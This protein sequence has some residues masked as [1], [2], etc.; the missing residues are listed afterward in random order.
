MVEF[1][2]DPFGFILVAASFFAAINALRCAFSNDEKMTTS[3]KLVSIVITL[4]L[5]YFTYTY[6]APARNAN[7]ASRNAPCQNILP[8]DYQDC[9][10]ANH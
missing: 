4:L 7:N 1:I 3:K 9:L 10:D 5:F 8:E 2:Q 6:T